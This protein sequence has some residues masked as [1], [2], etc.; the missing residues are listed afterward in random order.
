[1]VHGYEAAA[2]KLMA[3]LAAI[4][5]DL[6]EVQD[7]DRVLWHAGNPAVGVMAAEVW[8]YD[9]GRA[10]AER[11]VRVARS[12]G[13]LV[14]LQFALNFLANHLIIA[15]DLRGAAAL[16]DE[17]R[18]VAR[19]RGGPAVG[20]ADVILA[21][22]RGEEERTSV[23]VATTSET[24]A[25]DGHGR[26]VAFAEYAA[27]VLHNGLGRHE[28][29]LECAR[30]LFAEEVMGYQSLAVSELAEAASRTGDE[31]TLKWARRW[32]SV[33]AAEAP[34]DWA[35]GIEARVRALASKGRT[36]ERHFRESIERLDATPRE[37]RGRAGHVCCS[38]SGSAVKVGGARRATSCGLRT[39]CSR[40]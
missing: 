10:L 6:D 7:V 36:A 33:R 4:A 40:T 28:R 3:A 9:T 35:R 27:A 1:M 20:Y 11:Q 13:S 26:I 19:L 39:T 8:D 12:S 15:G 14:Q 32:V 25:G 17:D 29:A 31:A 5:R 24:A 18:L 22:F 16:L 2:P 30:R 23:L 34:T 37:G 38:E 21:A